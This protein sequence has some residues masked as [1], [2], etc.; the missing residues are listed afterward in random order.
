MK[1]FVVGLPADPLKMKTF[2][3]GLP[4]EGGSE[5]WGHY[6]VIYRS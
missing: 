2:V 6:N 4:A 1:T 5:R 3:A